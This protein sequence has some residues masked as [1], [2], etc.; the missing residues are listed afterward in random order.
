MFNCRVILLPFAANLSVEF[1]V[2]WSLNRE[3]QVSLY[4]GAESSHRYSKY[5]EAVVSVIKTV[6]EV[7]GFESIQSKEANFGSAQIYFRRSLSSV[8]E[9]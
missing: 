5:F 6:F 1:E 9:R 4:Q 2:T 3:S 8:Q 7:I